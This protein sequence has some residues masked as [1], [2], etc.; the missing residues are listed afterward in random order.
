MELDEHPTFKGGGPNNFASWVSTHVKYP[1]DAKSV[2]ALV[3]QYDEFVPVTRVYVNIELIYVLRSRKSD[4][5]NGL[6]A[7]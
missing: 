2:I 6:T 3:E 1:K 4:E 5:D 7:H